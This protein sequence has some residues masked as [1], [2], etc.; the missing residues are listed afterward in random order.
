[1]N[2]KNNKSRLYA[3][4]TC[5]HVQLHIHTLDISKCES[6]SFVRN[7][8]NESPSGCFHRAAK[9][10]ETAS[11]RRDRQSERQQEGGRERVSLLEYK[12][13]CLYKFSRSNFSKIYYIIINF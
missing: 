4:D 10:W 13:T 7:S 9:L 8:N 5:T 12:L 3:H 6:C 1:M 11:Q 2:M